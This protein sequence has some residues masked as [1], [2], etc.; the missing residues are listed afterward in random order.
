MTSKVIFSR[1]KFPPAEAR[2]ENTSQLKTIGTLKA[3]D[4]LPAPS[5]IFAKGAARCTE[6]TAA[7]SSAA[8]PEL[9]AMRMP[10][11]APLALMVKLTTTLPRSPPETSRFERLILM[12]TLPG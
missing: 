11:A 8:T 1:K 7:L 9:R 5:G 6:S 2:R 10:L 12:R 3:Q 4:D